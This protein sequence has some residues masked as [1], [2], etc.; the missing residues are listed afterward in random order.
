MVVVL[1]LLLWLLLLFVAVMVSVFASRLVLDGKG[2][3]TS[4]PQ[5]VHRILGLIGGGKVGLD[6]ALLREGATI[7]AN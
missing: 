6:T 1:L 2:Y 4:H 5:L 7:A 3:L